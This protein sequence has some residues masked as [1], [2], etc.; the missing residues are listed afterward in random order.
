VNRILQS[1][2][3]IYDAVEEQ[4]VAKAKAQMKRHL[5]DINRKH[6][7]IARKIERG[8]YKPPPEADPV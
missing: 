6:M 2:K 5:L 7:L 4:D 1:H 8:L 3:E